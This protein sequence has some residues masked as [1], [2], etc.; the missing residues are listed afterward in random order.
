MACSQFQEYPSGRKGFSIGFPQEVV[1]TNTYR[2]HGL[3]VSHLRTFYAWLFKLIPKEDLCHKDVFYS[4]TWDK[5]MMAPM[6]EMASGRYRFI[7]D[8]LY[9]YNSMNPIND[10]KV[11]GPLQVE[12]RDEIYAKE[13]YQRLECPIKRGIRT[14]LH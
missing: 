11:N 10:C 9:V 12:L 2:K 14:L 13:P 1:R 3:Y 6:I 7:D 4:M 5:A 8:I